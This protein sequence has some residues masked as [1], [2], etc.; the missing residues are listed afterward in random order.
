MPKPTPEEIAE[1]RATRQAEKDAARAVQIPAGQAR[2]NELIDAHADID[3]AWEAWNEEARAARLGPD[4]HQYI[5]AVRKR[6]EERGRLDPV[7]V[8]EHIEKNA[9]DVYHEEHGLEPRKGSSLRPITDE[10]RGIGLP[11]N[12]PG[13]PDA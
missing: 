5:I 2:A 11:K 9:D 3:A 6:F 4:Q 12:E 1:Y 8:N 10:E 7:I 13:N